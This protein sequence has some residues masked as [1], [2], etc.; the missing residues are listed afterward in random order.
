MVFTGSS[1]QFAAIFIGFFT[2]HVTT[3]LLAVRSSFVAIFYKGAQLALKMP[4]AKD[5]V[6]QWLA[7]FTFM[8]FYANHSLL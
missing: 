2:S 6:Q 1:S 4:S 3:P 5:V 7:S 8:C